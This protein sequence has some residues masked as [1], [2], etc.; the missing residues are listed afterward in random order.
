MKLGS[1]FGPVFFS[2]V[3]ALVLYDL[4]IKSAIAA[5]MPNKYDNTF[6]PSGSLNVKHIEAKRI[7]SEDHLQRLLKGDTKIS[8]RA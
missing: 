3:A 8:A 4:V 5:I 6:D 7:Q 2:V 1:I